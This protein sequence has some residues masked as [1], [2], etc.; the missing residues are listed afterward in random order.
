MNIPFIGDSG[1]C[2]HK[3]FLVILCI[4]LK[5]YLL[6]EFCPCVILFDVHVSLVVQSPTNFCL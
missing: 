5:F 3:H 2:A 4:H 6:K 1:S